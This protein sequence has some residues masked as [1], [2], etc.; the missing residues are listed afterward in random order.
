MHSCCLLTHAHSV[1]GDRLSQLRVFCTLRLPF[2][3]EGLGLDFPR[4]LFSSASTH[5]QRESGVHFYAVVVSMRR[6]DI[7]PSPVRGLYPSV[8]LTTTA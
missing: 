4:G 2:I 5:I 7:P 3:S 8:I 6:T 1:S